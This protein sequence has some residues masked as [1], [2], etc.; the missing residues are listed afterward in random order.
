MTRSLFA[1]KL[2]L[3][4]NG[5]HNE[6][7]FSLVSGLVL[8]ALVIA[9]ASASARGVMHE[10][11]IAV[12]IT[13]W[14]GMWL[15]G[16]LAQ[17]RHDPSVISREWLRG[18]PIRS[19]RLATALSW[20]E[21]LGVGPVIT[22]VCLSSLLVLA[23]PGGPAATVITAAAVLGQL[24]FLVWIGKTVA[25][26]AAWLLQTRVGMTLAGIQTAIM[27]AV[28]FA[29]WVPVASWLLPR[30]GDGETALV[31]PSLGQLSAPVVDVLTALP[32]G[33]GYRA[34]VA[35]RDGLGAGAV[36]LPLAGLL[37]AGALLQLTW[38]ALTARTLRRPPRRATPRRPTAP[39]WG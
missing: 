36:T 10:G 6:R 14:G 1:L 33:W 28:S 37:G 25:A 11:W 21:L 23:A 18:Y 34:A 19:W 16:P 15:F 5:P 4:R 27:L 39:R 32:T 20:T 30:L 22:V 7:G 24:Y 38:I 9:A 12:A 8:A 31:A 29:G 26:L 13:V 17:P 35:A 2:R 3:L